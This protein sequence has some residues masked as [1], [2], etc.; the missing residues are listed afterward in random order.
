MNIIVIGA[1]GFTGKP[2]VALALKQGHKVYAIS[3][4][5]TFDKHQNLKVIHKDIN[6]WQEIK[7]EVKDADIIISN[8]NAGWDNPN[9]YDDFMK[10]SKATVEFAK[11]LKKRIMIV[12][13]ASSLYHPDTNKQ[14]FYSAPKEMQVVVKGAF[15]LYEQLKNDKTFD[16]TFISPALDLNGNPAKGNYNVGG[17]FVLFNEKKESSISVYDL[18]DLLL[19]E[20]LNAT[21]HQKRITL[22]DR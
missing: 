18:A 4:K 13:G 3:R 21:S 16:W 14:V 9:F 12:G 17:D 2:V 22:A 10:G 11:F 19:K 7:D 6:Q 20:A 5:G 15:D 8:Y 1:S